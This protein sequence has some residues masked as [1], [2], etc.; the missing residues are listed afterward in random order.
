MKVQNLLGLVVVVSIG[1]ILWNMRNKKDAGHLGVGIDPSSSVLPNCDGLRSN[2]ISIINTRAGLLTSSTISL[3]EMGDDARNAEPKL[4][5]VRPIPYPPDV[6]YGQNKE[7]FEKER[8]ELLGQV[9]SRCQAAKPGGNSPIYQLV[10]Q[11]LAHLR[12]DK[13]RCG[14]NRNCTYLVKTDLDE[15]VDADLRETLLRAASETTV[16]TPQSLAG[17]L[18][19]E[20]IEVLFCGVAEVR[21]RREGTGS[22]ASTDSRMRIWAGLFTHRDL[23]SFQ[24][25]CK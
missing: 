15:G 16:D 19:N 17:S 11:G 25:Y 22:A 1:V 21:P 18:N 12:S 6:I 4:H 3:L 14:E 23:V 2:V 7:A 20:G 5:F 24:P 8:Q 10:K 13:L 9:E